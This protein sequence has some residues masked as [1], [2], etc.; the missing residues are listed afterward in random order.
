[1]SEVREADAAREIGLHQAAIDA[2]RLR[3][4]LPPELIPIFG[5]R[6]IRS[7]HLYD[8]FVYRLVLQVVHD[9]GLEA[10]LQEPG[11]AAELADRAKLE[12][13]RAVVPLDWML[14]LLASR[15]ALDEHRGGGASRFRVRAPF[16]SLDPV[17]VKDEQLRHDASGLPSYTLAE[18]VAREYPAFLRGERSGE[19]VLFTPRHIRLWIDYFSNDNGLYVVNNRVGAVALEQWLPRDGGTILE[20]GGGL[21]SGALAVLERLESMGRLGAVNE[22]RFTE[23]VPAF[24]RRG[25]QA[26]QA[27]YPAPSCLTFGAVDMNRPF[28]DQGVAPSSLSVVYA[29]NTL[30]VAHDLEL[31]LGEVRRALE[32]G[33]RLIVSECVRPR[34]GQP[35]YAEFVFNLTETFRSPRL[36]PLYRPGGGFLTPEQWRAAIEAAGFADVHF[37]PDIVRVREHVTDFFAAAIGSIQPD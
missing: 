20:L 7:H 17:A 28:A 27:R 3:E 24:L 32:P 34:P 11:D 33:G 15:G 5:A 26:L 9:V 13:R 6:F 8:E 23:F 36:H 30:H 21:G 19:E 4:I 12:P 22:Y 14:R 37:L 29:V 1:M 10:I 18:T 31:T 35:I 25:Q 16:P 2:A